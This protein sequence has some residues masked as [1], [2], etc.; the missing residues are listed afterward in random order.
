MQPC[1]V[2]ILEIELQTVAARTS[3][4]VGGGARF[5]PGLVNPK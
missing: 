2:P 5:F 4:E 3:E 1:L